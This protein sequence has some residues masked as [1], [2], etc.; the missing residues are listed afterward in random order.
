MA[1]CRQRGSRWEFTIKCK[2]VREKPFYFTFDDK[3]EGDLYVGR[4]EVL[5]RQ[6]VVPTELIEENKEFVIVGDVIRAY[7]KARAITEDDRGLLEA[8]FARVGVV[9]LTTVSYSWVENLVKGMKVTHNLAPSTIRHYVGA[10]ARCFDWGSNRGIPELVVNPLRLLPKGYATYNAHD[11]AELGDGMK[12]RT[13]IERDRRLEDDEESRIRA[14]MAGERRNDRERPLRLKWLG[15]TECMFD[16][17]LETAMRMRET[18]TLTLD[19]VNFGSRTIFLEKTKNGSKRQVPMSSVAIRVLQVYIKRVET[20]ERGME[21]FKFDGGRLFPWWNGSF[22]KADLRK[23]TTTLSQ[24]YARIFEFAGCE[25]VNYHD[26]RHEATSRLFER[27]SMSDGEI[28]KVTGHKS[29]RML[30]RYANLRGS[31]LADK[32]W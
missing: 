21:G 15:A 14:A 13:D 27:T 7:M 18:Y 6:G 28:M 31:R 19:Q 30:L 1:T 4:L 8:V 32:M 16:L 17:A 29:A 3:A 22:D 5:L 24:Q 12:A 26:L 10:L 2:S 25:D 23:V 20:A 9:R 11:R